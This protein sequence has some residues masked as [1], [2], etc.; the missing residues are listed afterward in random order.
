MSGGHVRQPSWRLTGDYRR[1]LSIGRLGSPEDVEDTEREHL[2]VDEC[3]VRGCRR[4]YDEVVDWVLSGCVDRQHWCRDLYHH[5]ATLERL[6][7]LT[8]IAR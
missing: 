3:E 5:D 2:T 4:S 6:L 8:L 7:G 1:A